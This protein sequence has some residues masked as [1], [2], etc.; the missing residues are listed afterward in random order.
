MNA[1]WG[2]MK[3][4]IGMT[5]VVQ[6]VEIPTDDEYRKI[7]EKIDKYE[8]TLS[9]VISA[10]ESV[11]QIQRAQGYELSRFGYYLTELAFQQRQNELRCAEH[12]VG[13]KFSN[14]LPSNVGGRKML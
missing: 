2:T 8:G 1:I 7:G 10:S 6:Q 11:Y 4:G 13:F 9:Q 14:V 5:T 12:K 3:E